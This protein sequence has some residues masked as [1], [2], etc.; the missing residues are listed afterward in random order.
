M[1]LFKRISA[2]IICA[3]I[4]ISSCAF[5]S[6]ATVTMQQVTTQ[7]VPNHA[8]VVYTKYNVT[9]SSSGHTEPATV[10]EFDPDDGYIPMAFSA[11]HG[12]SYPV[13]LADH[14]DMAVNK[15]GYD[16]AGV[17]N[18]DYFSMNGGQINGMIIQNGKIA[19]THVG[20]KFN[21]V[22]FDKYGNMNCVESLLDYKLKINGAEIYNGLRYLNKPQ[23]NDTW[24]PDRIFYY[25]TSCG[26]SA[27]TDTA[28]YE[29]ICR[30]I[31]NTE[32]IVGG[33]MI[34][35]VVE[36]KTN[37]YGSRLEDD[38]YKE[39]DKFILYVENGSSYAQY[40][41]GLKAGDSI[42]ITVE[43]TVEASK[44]VMKNANSA[45]INVGYLIKDGVDQ[46]NVTANL[47][48]THGWATYYRTTVFGQKA[49]GSYVFFTSDGGDTGS[50]ARS[51]NLKDAAAALLQLGCVNAICMDGGGSTSMY[52]PGIGY[53]MSTTRKVSDCILIVKRSSLIDETVNAQ[54]RAKIAEAKQTEMSAS[55]SAV[56]AEGEA[57]L[58]DIP[59]K[60]EVVELMIRLD[61]AMSGISELEA[62]LA[63]AEG[64]SY[65]DYNEATLARIRDAY[66]E[67]KALLASGTPDSASVNALSAKLEALLNTQCTDKV[68]NGIYVHGFNSFIYTGNCFIYTPDFGTITATNANHRYASSAICKWDATQGAYVVTR[69]IIGTGSVS[70]VTL[71]SDEIMIAAHGDSGT[72]AANKA[73]ITNAKV[74][75]YLN[76]YGIDID[77]KSI[78]IAA[79][80]EFSDTLPE[81]A[82]PADEESSEYVSDE[83]SED[84]SDE[85]SDEEVSTEPDL[86]CSLWLTHYNDLTVEGAG[87]IVTD[88]SKV[89][90]SGWNNYYAFAPV[91]GS[92]AYE[93]VAVSIGNTIGTSA[94][95][96]IPTGG[97]VY[98]LNQGN[99]Y[100][101][102]GMDGPDYTSD[103]CMNMIADAM[104]WKIG[105]RFVFSGIDL[106]GFTVPT[107]TPDVKWYDDAYVC[108]ATYE[109]LAEEKP[110]SLGD[111]DGNGE[112]DQFDYLLI[113]R[114]YFNTYD[115]TEEEQ[116]RAD[117]NADNTVDQFD[118]MIIKRIYFNTYTVG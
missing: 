36:L 87:V 30:K 81:E 14:Y 48:S 55:L 108:T 118:Y 38:I 37:S 35:E 112:I 1:K 111:V 56:V 29:V 98:S 83:T 90:S 49:D 69:K 95:P 94:L 77:S 103:S 2:F 115:L 15:Y 116:K 41:S 110:L 106:E 59:L 3:F 109:K 91:E 12:S 101:A 22:A 113:K 96:D 43:E 52:V 46:T 68:T 73:K 28:G 6:A 88:A 45:L 39:S 100:P 25:D 44:E 34:G 74:G 53:V 93:L 40:V 13:L 114:F 20:E 5:V 54:L 67:G 33:T 27:D 86:E 84:T 51:L 89:V 19:C 62:L 57:L 42:E 82:P 76:I 97:F 107:S 24:A 32:L 60:H 21:V 63:R 99:N 23:W 17:I 75:Q 8:S 79:Y 92:S 11:Y 50:S 61:S 105:D 104:N 72:D 26:R 70:N 65:T 31:N 10:L 4:L 64:I 18:G 117:V 66:S 16:V 80:V 58:N 47:D 102:I 7:S 71:A 9:G 85:T 78:G